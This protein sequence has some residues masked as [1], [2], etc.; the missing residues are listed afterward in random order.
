MLAMKILHKIMRQR[1][2]DL[3]RLALVMHVE[4]TFDRNVTRFKS[5]I[6]KV[7]LCLRDHRREM[8]FK[9]LESQRSGSFQNGLR[10]IL[11]YVREQHAERG[12]HTGMLRNDDRRH[13]QRVCDLARMHTTCAAKGEQGEVAWIVPALHGDGTNSALH[14]RIGNLYNTFG[15]PC[16]SDVEPLGERSR[17]VGGPRYIELHPAAEKVFPIE[18][19]QQ[20]ICIRHRKLLALAVAGRSRIGARAARPDTQRA[21]AIDICDRSATRANRMNIEHRQAH[22]RIADSGFVRRS[23]VA[24]DEAYIG[25]CATHIEK[26]DALEPRGCLL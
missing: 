24:V 8:R 16:R 13:L 5:L 21:A 25:R 7:D 11:A 14:T 10:V 2:I 19:A 1:Q 9:V 17:N 3:I 23:E 6:C 15:E 4:R 22:W 20:E 12:K 26:N 18:P